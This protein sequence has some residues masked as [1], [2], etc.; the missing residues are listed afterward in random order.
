MADVWIPSSL[1]KY[2]DGL[3]QIQVEGSTIRQ[4]ISNLEL[5]YPMTKNKLADEHGILPG[6]AVI[7]DGESTRL[8]LLE[9]VQSNSEIH[10]LPALGGG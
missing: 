6:I 8:G 10:F 1:Q 4:I 7:I 9:P 3:Q 5:R 2:T